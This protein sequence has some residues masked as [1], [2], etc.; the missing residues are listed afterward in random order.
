MVCC[1]A[2]SINKKLG[3]L[4]D[5]A[6]LCMS[7]IAIEGELQ[8]LLA[9]R[10]AG[11]GGLGPVHWA[12]LWHMCHEMQCTMKAK[13]L[14]QQSVHG[15]IRGTKSHARMFTTARMQHMGSRLGTMS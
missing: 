6:T 3:T 12:C 1:A 7:C 15:I 11:G 13:S 8:A 2:H 5:A 10:L 9:D 4:I 14:E